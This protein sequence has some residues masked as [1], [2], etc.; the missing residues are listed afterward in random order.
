MSDV[1]ALEFVF[2]AVLCKAG[3]DPRYGIITEADCEDKA[4]HA[5]YCNSWALVFGKY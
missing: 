1:I 2:L 5:R 4:D 3:P